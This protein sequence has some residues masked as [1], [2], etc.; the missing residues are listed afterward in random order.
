MELLRRL[1]INRDFGLLFVGRLVSQVGDGVHYFAM[2]WLVLDLTGSGAALGT[3]LLTASIPGVVLAPFTGVLADTLNRK[4]IVVSMDIVR[5]ILM[6]ALAGTY[7]AGQLTLPVLYAATLLLSLCGVLFGPAIAATIPGLV[8]REELVKANARDTFSHGATGILGPIAGAFLLGGFGYLGIFVISGSTFLISAVSEMF[9]RFPKQQ[10]PDVSADP[11]ADFVNNLK[12][13]FRYLWQN[14]GLRVLMAGGILLNFLFNPLFG[15][16]F[17]FFGKEVLLMAP[18]HL[19]LSQ[20][21]FPVGMLIG[22]LLVAF[23]AQRVSKIKLLV[24]GITIQGVLI[25]TLGLLALPMV[26][27]QLS[28]L[29]ILGALALPLFLMGV[30]NVQVNV[31]L[32]VMMQETVP[33][34]YRGRVFALFGSILQ[35]AAPLGMGLFGV[36]LDIIPIYYFFWFSGAAASVTALLVGASPA[37]HRL[38][39]ST[40]QSSDDGGAAA[41]RAETPGR[42]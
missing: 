37:L 16:V 18:E 19:G 27:S 42:A 26:Y 10:K 36:L 2:A 6:L 24:G 13:G 33:D 15:V 9:I 35:L 4:T 1:F 17:P 38:Y 7:A 3:L 25:A 30:L 14:P 11:K 5:G 8:K 29:S 21:S 41:E 20:S 40:L 23:L 39:E 32:Q 28:A 22:T 31:P 12:S 34:L